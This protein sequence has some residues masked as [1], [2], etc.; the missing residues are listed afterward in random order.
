MPSA[1]NCPACTTPVSACIHLSLKGF[2]V[3]RKPQLL[4]GLNSAP[5]HHD[6]R[7]N[8]R[9][10]NLLAGREELPG[11]HLSSPTAQPEQKITT[12]GASGPAL[13]SLLF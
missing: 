6:H 13:G 3:L 10:W 9:G 8:T 4:V 1:L 12:P 7:L 11:A 2:L 5:P